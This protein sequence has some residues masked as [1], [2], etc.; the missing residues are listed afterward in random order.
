VL[1]DRKPEISMAS[2]TKAD[3]HMSLH[4]ASVPVFGQYLRA[5]SAIL[6]KAEAHADAKKI[7]HETMLGLR[8]SPDMF[9]VTRQVQVACDFAKNTSAR[10]AGVE[11][12]RMP[13]EEKTFAELQQRITRTLEFIEGI[14]AA[15]FAGAETKSIEFPIARKPYRM[16]GSAY[17][18]HFAMPNFYFHATVAY[19]ILRANGVDVGKGDFMGETK[20]LEA[21]A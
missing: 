21:V 4:T 1:A 16:M 19:A 2:I 8:L 3:Q 18:H 14:P 20:G 11:I 12:P 9:A 10:L 6:A 7:A 5:L 13:D 17:L 15:S